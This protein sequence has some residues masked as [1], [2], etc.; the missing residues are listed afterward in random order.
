MKDGIALDSPV[1]WLLT[2]H[3]RARKNGI[4]YHSFIM[5]VEFKK[6]REIEVKMAK[7]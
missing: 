5:V 6:E 2:M 4:E 3:R 1:A 7:A